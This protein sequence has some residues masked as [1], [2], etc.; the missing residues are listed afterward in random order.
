[1]GECTRRKG[2]FDRGHW[3]RQEMSGGPGL[4]SGTGYGNRPP[5]SFPEFGMS[6]T[7]AARANGCETRLYPTSV[8]R[9]G[10]AA[11]GVDV[12]PT[13]FMRSALLTRAAVRT[14]C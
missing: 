1:M 6:L 7:A 4:S 3:I 5:R 9:R 12:S 2:A 14:T 8:N 11:E 13:I 10:R